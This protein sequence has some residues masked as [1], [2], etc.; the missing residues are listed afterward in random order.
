MIVDRAGL[1]EMRSSKVRV[2]KRHTASA[3]VKLW[4]LVT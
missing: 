2:R 3:E 4:S 1:Q